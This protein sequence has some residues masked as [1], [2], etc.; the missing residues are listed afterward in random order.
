MLGK[1]VVTMFLMRCDHSVTVF[2][3]NE[4]GH[5]AFVRFLKNKTR[6]YN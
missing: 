5:S 6:V 3:K 1:M 4:E 2:A